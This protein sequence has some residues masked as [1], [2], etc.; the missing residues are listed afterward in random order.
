MFLFLYNKC[1]ISSK[2]RLRN[3]LINNIVQFSPPVCTSTTSFHS[4]EK[5]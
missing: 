1:I 3:A 4:V 5:T 2:I